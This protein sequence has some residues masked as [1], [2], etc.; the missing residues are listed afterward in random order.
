MSPDDLKTLALCIAIL[1]VFLVANGL[2]LLG[3]FVI[4]LAALFTTGGQAF[5]ET[6]GTLEPRS[7]KEFAVVVLG[8]FA[9]LIPVNY[10]I[11]STVKGSTPD[12]FA[13]DMLQSGRGAFL[14]LAVSVLVAA[15][16]EEIVFRGFLLTRLS[17]IF[18]TGTAALVL[19]VGLTSLVFGMGHYYQTGMQSALMIGFLSVLLGV[20]FIKTQF[21]LGYAIAIHLLNNLFALVANR[22]WS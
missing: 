1:V 5:F 2:V 17:D 20:I 3:G 16:L 6:L 10:L 21:N 14:L 7:W 9:V 11:M 19:T 12:P 15:V 4:V 13:Q 22:L 8:A 18:G